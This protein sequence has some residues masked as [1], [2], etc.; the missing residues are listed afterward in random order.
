MTGWYAYSDY[1]T[2]EVMAI[3]SSGEGTGITVNPDADVLGETRRRK[4]QF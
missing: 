1:C 2:G 4:D 3:A